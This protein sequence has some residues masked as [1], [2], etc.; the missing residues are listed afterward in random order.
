MSKNCIPQV[1]ENSTFD[2]FD[3]SAPERRAAL[4]AA[5][6]LAEKLASMRDQI[7]NE[8]HPFKRARIFAFWGKPGRGKTHLVEALVNHLRQVAP[9]I[10]EKIWLSRSDFTLDNIIRP[11]VP[12]GGAPIVIPDDLFVEFQDVSKLHPNT[13]VECFMRFVRQMYEERRIVIVTTNVPFTEGILGRVAECDPSGRTASRLAEMLAPSSEIEITGID[14]R[15][16]AA[17]TAGDDL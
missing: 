15:T 11:S 10:V 1:R 4:D 2:S 12:Y 7:L 9:D 13:D 3:A 14:Y 17:E 5:R 16:V 8:E 6:G